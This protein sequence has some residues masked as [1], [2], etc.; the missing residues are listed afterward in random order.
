[1][2]QY[3]ER[4]VADHW[5]DVVTA[6]QMLDQVLMDLPEHLQGVVLNFARFLSAQ[7]ERETWMK[8]GRTHLEKAYGKEE[9]DYT[10]A[11]IKPDLSR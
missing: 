2:P 1:M 10:E 5:R 3:L 6:K 7:E 9:P 8:F 4:L 11:D